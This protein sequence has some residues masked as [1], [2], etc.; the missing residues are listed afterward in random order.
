MTAARTAPTAHRTLSAHPRRRLRC[1][2]VPW[3]TDLPPAASGGGSRPGWCS[4]TPGAP[5][6]LLLFFLVLCRQRPNR[7]GCH[8]LRV[9]TS[10]KL[11]FLV[12]T[13]AVRPALLRGDEA[14]HLRLAWD[15]THDGFQHD[16]EPHSRHTNQ[17]GQKERPRSPGLNA[18]AMFPHTREK[19]QPVRLGKVMGT[20]KGPPSDGPPAARVPALPAGATPI[21]PRWAS[22]PERA[23]Q[24]RS[25]GSNGRHKPAAVVVTADRLDADRLPR[26]RRVHHLPASDVHG[27]V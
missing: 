5:S 7:D 27:H 21:P 10:S 6:F 13:G 11:R 9:R 2:P 14:L 1:R 23:F 22:A 26:P 4:R 17:K 19:F 18:F 12:R 24:R 15:F 3:L 8:W 20:E 16:K 25:A